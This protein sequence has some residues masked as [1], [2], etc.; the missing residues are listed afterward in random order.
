MQ[1]IRVVPSLAS[2]ATSPPLE[3]GVHTLVVRLA[4]LVG[5]RAETSTTFRVDTTEPDVAFTKPEPDAWVGVSQLV[6]LAFS[7]SGSGLLLP[8]DS[9]LLHFCCFG[10][11]HV[12]LCHCIVQLISHLFI[13]VSCSVPIFVFASP[14][15]AA[16]T[17]CAAFCSRCCAC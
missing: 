16:P 17:V 3:D 8:Q 2:S 6:S 5:N 12:P 1:K 11:F 9:H 10:A 4:D 7:D 15:T 14:V 13:M